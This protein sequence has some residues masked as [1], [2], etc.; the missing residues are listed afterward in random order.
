MVK[1]Y[2]LKYNL[3]TFWAGDICVLDENGDLWWQGNPNPEINEKEKELHWRDKV[4]MYHAKTLEKFNILDTY[5]EEVKDISKFWPFEGCRYFYV[6]DS[7]IEWDIW[8]DNPIDW[9]RKSLGNCFLNEE[10][11][12]K[13]WRE[14]KAIASIAQ[15]GGQMTTF[16]LN[17][18]GKGMITID[19]LPEYRLKIAE[20]LRILLE[21]EK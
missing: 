19:F 2:K 16:Q 21:N 6:V 17:E 12:G 15:L 1:V 8:G 11:A 14:Y 3:P 9:D 20:N 4:C 18:N 5:F 10:D 7:G 13:K